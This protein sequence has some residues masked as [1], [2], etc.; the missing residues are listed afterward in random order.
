[1]I[2]NLFTFFL[3]LFVCLFVFL[4]YLF[5][6]VFC[7]FV[8]KNKMRT[9]RG[10]HCYEIIFLKVCTIVSIYCYL[11]PLK[12]RNMDYWEVK[13]TCKKYRS[14][15]NPNISAHVSQNYIISNL[16][17]FCLFVCFFD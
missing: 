7:I 2:S 8:D 1:M 12:Y 17:T 10:N 6:C 15:L 9:G 3:F 13:K 14:V 4:V 5:V 16:F 11:Y